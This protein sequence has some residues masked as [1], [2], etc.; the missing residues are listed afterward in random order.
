MGSA[1]DVWT[2]RVGV[3]HGMELVSCCFHEHD[4]RQDA[5]PCQRE[6]QRGLRPYVDGWRGVPVATTIYLGRRLRKV[7]MV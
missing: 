4:S 7:E 3:W 6:I 1:P 2:W 5:E